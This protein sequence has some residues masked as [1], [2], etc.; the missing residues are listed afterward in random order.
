[1][2]C[3]VR[4]ECGGR[5]LLL[6]RVVRGACTYSLDGLD[7][8]NKADR[9]RRRRTFLHGGKNILL[10]PVSAVRNLQGREEIILRKR[11]QE[12]KERNGPE[13]RKKERKEQRIDRETWARARAQEARS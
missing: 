4:K 6:E 13:K 11:S 10:D 12:R 7:G 1:M 3:V 5:Y 9:R 2:C 8:K